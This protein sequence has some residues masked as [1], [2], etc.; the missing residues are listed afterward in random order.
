MSTNIFGLGMETYNNDLSQPGTLSGTTTWNGGFTW[1]GKGKYSYPIA[2]A[3]GNI[4]PLTNNDPTNNA[5]YKFGLPR[6]LKWQYRKGIVTHPQ[7]TI[8]NPDKPGEYIEVSRISH[9]SKTNA[10]IAQ[11]IDQPGGYTVKH[12]PE[13]EINGTTQLNKDCQKC[14]GIGLVASYAPER[15]LTNNPEPC[16]TNSEIPGKICC[17][18][19]ANAKRRVIYANTNLPQNYYTTHHQYLQN[20]CQTYQQK[21]FNF[22][23]SLAGSVAVDTHYNVQIQPKPGSPL[24]LSNTY[25]AN[26]YPNTDEHT[27]SQ[28][29]IINRIYLLLKSQPGIF[30]EGDLSNYNSQQINTFYKM[31]DFLSTIE[32]DIEKALLVYTNFITN[33]YVGI[34]LNGPSNPRGCKRVIYKPSNP[35]FAV[36]GGVSSGTRLLKLTTDTINTNIADIRKLSGTSTSNNPFI[37]KNKYTTCQNSNTTYMRPL[38]QNRRKCAL[39]QTLEYQRVRAFSQ[40]G[41]IGGVVNGTQVSDVGMTGSFN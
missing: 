5:K 28:L 22:Q 39:K 32:G 41:N 40:L 13:T 35:Q 24:A 2:I 18:E 37:Y 8:I 16:V 36:E 31:K 11:T 29:N 6:P 21:I 1:K 10:L 17:N 7:V 30:T 4:R 27:Y 3:S 19:A 25:I 15:Y 33:P 23:S 14:Y 38:G 12:N 26:C 9:S 34:P 20:R